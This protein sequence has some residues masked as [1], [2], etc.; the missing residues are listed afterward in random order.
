MSRE[1]ERKFLVN[2]L[3]EDLSNYSYDKILQGYLNIQS[4][5][6]EMRLRKKDNQYFQTIKNGNGLNR[7]EIEIALTKEQFVVLWPLTKNYRIVKR[8]YNIP[9]NNY[10]IELDIYEDKYKGLKAC[11]VEFPSEKA[12]Y[13]F[14]PPAWVG[15]EIT[16]EFSLQNN[17]LALNG[18]S[19][20]I[21]HKYNIKI[22]E[23]NIY[24]QSGAIPI[25]NHNNQVEVLIITS[26]SQ[27]K[28]TFP[29]GIIEH[30]LAAEE[31]AQKEAY[32]E[33]GVLGSVSKKIGHY[34]YDKWNGTCQVEMFIMEDAKELNDWPE[35]FRKR[36]WVP[37]KSLT[38][39]IKKDEL[40]PIIDNLKQLVNR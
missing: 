37:V 5:D 16:N 39:Y 27:K 25:R 9:Y 20:R 11:E 29:K 4:D 18:L 26:S 22:E 2:A 13:Q 40:K 34:E 36:K 15:E 21:I 24:E 14:Q 35:D 23:E 32:E 10:L 12:A 1:I 3:P 17:R 6:T 7:E 8:R 33:A 28:W 31:S 30:G 19:E 38:D